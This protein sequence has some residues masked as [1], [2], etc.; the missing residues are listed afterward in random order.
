LNLEGKEISKDENHVK[1]PEENND[2]HMGWG[3]ADR[4]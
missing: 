4:T 2:E 3:G 1:N